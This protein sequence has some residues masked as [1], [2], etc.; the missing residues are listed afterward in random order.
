VCWCMR[1]CL[2]LSLFD[3]VCILVC[4]CV[5]L[6]VCVYCDQSS[7]ELGAAQRDV[8]VQ[9]EGCPA[10]GG[11]TGTTQQQPAGQGSGHPGQCSGQS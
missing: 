7:A 5:S 10:G 8:P 3:Y 6:T 4:V 11:Q 1:A 2:C 9:T